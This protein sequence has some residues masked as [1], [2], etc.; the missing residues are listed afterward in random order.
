MFNINIFQVNFGKT[1]TNFKEY[2]LHVITKVNEIYPI[3]AFCIM[4]NGPLLLLLYMYRQH[5]NNTS[6]HK[7]LCLIQQNTSHWPYSTELVLGLLHLCFFQSYVNYA[8]KKQNCLRPCTECCHKSTSSIL[9]NQ[10]IYIAVLISLRNKYITQHF[11]KLV[12]SSIK[13]MKI[14][15]YTYFTKVHVSLTTNNGF[16]YKWW[17]LTNFEYPVDRT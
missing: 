8:Q 6:S 12:L 10:L 16:S 1:K 2:M 11:S 9:K 13:A 7:L 4:M 14:I 5:K 3:T 17:I 15:K